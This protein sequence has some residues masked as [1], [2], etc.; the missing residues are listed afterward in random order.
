MA[1]T[2]T[3]SVLRPDDLLVLNVEFINLVRKEIVDPQLGTITALGRQNPLQS[4]FSIVHFPWQ[5]IVKRKRAYAM[6]LNG[7]KRQRV[8]VS[9]CV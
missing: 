4:A 9:H 8:V 1:E 6:L 5:H 3:I 7:S 2:L